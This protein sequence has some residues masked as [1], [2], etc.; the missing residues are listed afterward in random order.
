MFKFDLLNHFAPL[1]STFV[2]SIS[3]AYGRVNTF[4]EQNL[5]NKK[6]RYKAYRPEKMS[7]FNLKLVF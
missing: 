4:I 7:I 6:G 5:G 1:C 2:D 3:S